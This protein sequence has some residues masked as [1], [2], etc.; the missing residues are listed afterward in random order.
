MST[1]EADRL[2]YLLWGHRVGKEPVMLGIFSSKTEVD[3]A[4]AQMRDCPE[5]QGISVNRW[6]FFFDTLLDRPI[7]IYLLFDCSPSIPDD[8][9]GM[10]N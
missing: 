2:V 5:Y 1:E 8:E 3:K 6:D 4:T 9:D 7:P 10:P